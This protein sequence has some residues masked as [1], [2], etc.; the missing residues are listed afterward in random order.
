MSQ[1][2]PVDDKAP[3]RSP[4]ERQLNVG[5]MVVQVVAALVVVYGV[6]FVVSSWDGD[7]DRTRFEALQVAFVFLL[8]PGLVVLF[9]ARSARR[10]L[11]D[12]VV[13]ARLFSILAGAFA[14]LASLPLL[15]TVFG[16][17]IAVAGLFTVTA[18]F[19]LKKDLLR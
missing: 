15:T 17:V 5:L 7:G 4:M 12:Q 11:K 13:S 9:T 6:V 10:R 1:T 14:L 8:L 19:M 16:I 18:A 3:P 2:N